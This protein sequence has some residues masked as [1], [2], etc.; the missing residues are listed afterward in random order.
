MMVYI[1][2][3]VTY[4]H[5]IY[6]DLILGRAGVYLDGYVWHTYTLMVK[7]SS[8]PLHDFLYSFHLSN[9][10]KTGGEVSELRRFKHRSV[11]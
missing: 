2:W 3:G 8:S 1:G 10:M 11:Y 7:I 9:Q 4:W 6:G 5:S